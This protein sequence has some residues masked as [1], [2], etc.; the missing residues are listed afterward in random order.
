M[1]QPTLKSRR[2]IDPVLTSI[3]HGYNQQ[4]F[5]GSFLFPE[6]PVEKRA[7]NVI[8]FGKE[9]FII[10]NTRRAPGAATMRRSV[11]YSSKL[12]S[13]RQDAIEGELPVEDLEESS[14]MPFDLQR[15]TAESAMRS[16]MLRLEYDQAQIAT[17]TANY[18]INSQDT[19]D[20][21]GGVGSTNPSADIETW[22]EV[23][24]SRIG[25]YPNSAI[26]GSSVAAK[27]KNDSNLTDRIKYTSDRSITEDMLAT[28]WDLSRGVRVGKSLVADP[29][30]GELEDIWANVV[31]LAYVPETISSRRAPSYGYTYTLRNYPMAEMPYYDQNHRTW[32]FPVVAERSPELTGIDAGF[33]ATVTLA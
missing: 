3:L 32:Y 25:V 5:V 6:V 31:I 20:W 28:W 16:L 29:T 15:E 26:I 4:E 21:S 2:V 22:K 19:P 12:Y 18:D 10:Y 23:V 7:G 14:D 30:T 8:E 27:L 17:D 33:L 1:P 24:R 11:P 13:L 9:D